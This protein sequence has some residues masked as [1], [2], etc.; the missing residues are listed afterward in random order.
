VIALLLLA[1][2]AGP[3]AERSAAVYPEQSLP[4]A[5]DHAQHLKGGADC[6]TCHDAARKS[7]RAED[8]NLPGHPECEQ[9]HGIKAA[10]EGNLTDPRSDCQTCHPGFDQTARAAPSAVLFPTPNLR[11]NHQVHVDRKVD[12]TVCHDSVPRAALATR[13]ELPKMATCLRCHDGR[14][15]S[16]DCAT[17][18][19]SEPGGRLRLTFASGVLRPAAGNPLGLDHGP[20]YD[21][22]HGAR[23]A[24]DRAACLA[25]HAQSEC[26]QCHDGT[27]KPLAI[28]PG[29]W[30]TTHPAAVRGDLVQCESCHRLQSFC[31]ACHERAG[32]GMDADPTLLARNVL[33]H[34]NSDS[35]TGTSHADAGHHGIQASRDLRQCISCH[36]EESCL[37]CHAGDALA[38]RLST[39]NPHPAGFR[40][41]C[42]ALMS[43]NDR[44]CLRCHSDGVLAGWGC[45]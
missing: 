17:C 43:R 34:R 39:V 14:R 3:G 37:R 41:Q 11:F 15:A 5:F 35:F 40:L 10:A 28:H 29:D 23:A 13:A 12:C 21:R 45:R 30:I 42:R 22:T 2:A 4:L 25:C 36:R 1:M 32:I 27:R 26:E 6:F 38:T 24:Q 7:T 18:H 44:P 16:A 20:R 33:V 31:A 9:C 8:R 19:L